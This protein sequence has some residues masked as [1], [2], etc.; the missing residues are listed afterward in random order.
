MRTLARL[1]VA[2]IVLL[3]LAY[4]V[5]STYLVTQATLVHRNVAEASPADVG[6]R[7][8]DVAFTS[9]DGIRLQG[10]YLPASGARAVVLVHG[11]DGNR[12]DTVHHVDRLVALL[13][14][15]GYDVLTFDL[16]G[17]GASGG[18]R[19]GLAW[20]ERLDVQAAVRYVSSRGV[21]A[22]RIGLWGQ[23]LGG[24]AA[25]LAMPD[26]PE[27][28]AVVSDAAF[29]DIRLV[30]DGEIQRRVGLP[31][32]FTPGLT[33]ATR[34]LYGLD[35]AVIPP[36]QAVPR[37]APRPILLIHGTGDRRI[38][39]EHAYRL[40]AAARGPDDELWIVPEAG[41]VLSY[42][43]EPGPYATKVLALFARAL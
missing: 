33:L 3:V 12:W 16:R 24:A 31:P 39:V 38:P 26:V 30:L 36:E 23:S 21:A 4:A 13:V 27:V 20:N 22:G 11:I 2:V 15:A 43:R 35:L 40:R 25:L 17:S 10:W 41:H 1:V 6:L 42:D 34:V 18:E 7:F 8:E 28:S 19:L 14:G 32:I 37:I 5:A 29:A 9:A